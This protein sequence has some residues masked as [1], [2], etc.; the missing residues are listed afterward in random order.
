MTGP[1]T[2]GTTIS[3]GGAADID[4]NVTGGG[5]VTFGSAA[6]IAGN[7]SGN[8]VSVAG[9]LA[10]DGAGGQTVNAGAGT[11]VAGGAVTKSGGS[12]VTLLARQMDFNGGVDSVNGTGSLFIRTTDAGGKI[13][14][15]NLTGPADPAR[16]DLS[17][18]DVAAIGTTFGNVEIGD[19]A[20]TRNI[21]VGAGAVFE[22]P[23]TLRVDALA[24]GSSAIQ[25]DL[26]GSLTA[27]TL[28]MQSRGQVLLGNNGGTVIPLPNNPEPQ[29]ANQIARLGDVTVDGEFYL[30]DG[31]APVTYTPTEVANAPFYLDGTIDNRRGLEI[32]GD[33]TQAATLAGTRTVIRTAG[34]LNIL[35]GS[36]ITT[37]NNSLTVM[38]AEIPTG[39]GFLANFHNAGAT[40]NA[41]NFLPASTDGIEVGINSELLVYS[42]DVN[43]NTFQRGPA[44]NVNNSSLNG[45]QPV[46]GQFRFGRIST[47]ANGPAQNFLAD[48]GKLITPNVYALNPGLAGAV[49]FVIRSSTIPAPPEASKFVFFDF[50]LEPFAG[51]TF[52]S[53]SFRTLGRPRRDINTHSALLYDYERWDRGE[54]RTGEDDTDGEVN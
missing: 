28:S 53:E 15:G 18:A 43:F 4:G 42:S 33:F 30:Y 22:S 10:L 46:G 19:M 14:I 48:F 16:L 6:S 13:G 29:P 32:A 39:G 52:D 3:I 7:L 44:V 54:G 40:D 23:L 11:F 27:G 1:L 5:A 49:Q 9:V 25:Q 47:V 2:A 20:S 26:T 8:G 12:D 34:D 17:A 45:V 21:R 50:N 38:S 24:A 37:G 35:P 41:G 51:V 31:G 36:K